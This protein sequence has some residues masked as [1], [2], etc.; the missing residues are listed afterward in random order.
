M[1]TET[2]P[3]TTPSTQHNINVECQNE[4][5]KITDAHKKICGKSCKSKDSRTTHTTVKQ[6]FDI[7]CK[8]NFGYSLPWT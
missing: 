1:W 7:V 2:F 5:G 8:S 6:P 4:G 3:I